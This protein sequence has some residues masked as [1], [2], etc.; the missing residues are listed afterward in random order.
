[1]FDSEVPLHTTLLSQKIRLYQR[2][3]QPVFRKAKPKKKKPGEAQRAEKE[4]IS[5]V[6]SKETC[7]DNFDT[8]E[9]SNEVRN[10][11]DII[12]IH[13]DPEQLD[14][15]RGD[16][17]SI[18]YDLLLFP[19]FIPCK[20]L[21]ALMSFYYC[22]IYSLSFIY[23]YPMSKY[24]TLSQN[25]V[26]KSSHTQS[27]LIRQCVVSILILPFY[28]CIKKQQYKIIIIL[29]ITKWLSWQ[30]GGVCERAVRVQFP[31]SKKLDFIKLK[32]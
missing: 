17:S 15:L 25:I 21:I 4:D 8:D 32:L 14:P 27:H 10:I 18:Y 13:I 23:Q 30:S 20:Y 31:K 7:Q 24:L 29:P 1:M 11:K 5:A 16:N 12:N 2:S 19:W 9:I 6:S 28:Q 22:C 26:Q 3:V